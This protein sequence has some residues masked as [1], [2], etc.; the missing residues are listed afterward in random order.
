MNSN[1]NDKFDLSSIIYT[2]KHFIVHKIRKQ[3]TNKLLAKNVHVIR[4]SDQI[5]HMRPKVA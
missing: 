2:Q 3:Y 1:S 5:V 4:H